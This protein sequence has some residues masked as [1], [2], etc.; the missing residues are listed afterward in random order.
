MVFQRLVKGYTI[1]D[2]WVAELKRVRPY[3]HI[4]Y[5]VING[6]KNMGFILYRDSIKSRDTS[7]Y[8]ER[9]KILILYLHHTCYIM[10]Y[11]FYE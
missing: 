9:I 3:T 5:V 4:I 6:Y 11:V 2:V 8:S 1:A 7:I 10:F